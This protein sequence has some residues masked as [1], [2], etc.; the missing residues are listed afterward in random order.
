MA[1]TA[2]GRMANSP[3]EAQSVGRAGLA[4]AFLALTAAG[5]R[6]ASG[7][8][9]AGLRSYVETRMAV[10]LEAAAGKAGPARDRHSRHCERERRRAVAFEAE[11]ERSRPICAGARM[12][13]EF[14]FRRFGEPRRYGGIMC[15]HWGRRKAGGSVATAGRAV[16][17]A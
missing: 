13:W 1:K 2:T 8:D 14:T 7:A 5:A 12:Q 3:A 9:C 16:N 17:L 4:L 6:A 11:C 15:G 10:C